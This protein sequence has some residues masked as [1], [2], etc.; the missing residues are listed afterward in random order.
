MRA[1]RDYES[2]KLRKIIKKAT[3]PQMID[4]FGSAIEFLTALQSL[5]LPNWKNNAGF[6]EAA[7]WKGWDWRINSQAGA[8]SEVR[9]L[10][11]RAS[12]T[13]YRT[14]GATMHSVSEAVRLVEAFSR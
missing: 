9:I 3:A 14:W 1:V 8:L 5:D 7:D 4:R 10:R 12:S 11:R 6:C 2:K 13:N